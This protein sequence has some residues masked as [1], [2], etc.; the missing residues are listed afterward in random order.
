MND[1]RKALIFIGSRSNYGRL[2]QLI[3]RMSDEYSV[4]LCLACMGVDL[5]LPRY[6]E[7]LVALRVRAD[8]RSDTDCNMA[9]TM[10][11]VALLVQN[12]LVNNY[13][14][15]AVCHGD[16][17]E[18]LGFAVACSFAKIPLVHMEA[19]EYSGNIDNKIRWAVSSLADLQLAPSRLSN[20]N[21]D[22]LA[23]GKNYFVGSPAVEYIKRKMGRFN[24]RIR[25]K[26][27]LVLYHP[28]DSSELD[29]LLKFLDLITEDE[30]ITWVNPNIDPGNKGIVE[31]IKAF[32][33]EHKNIKFEKN[34]PLDD[35]LTRL[36]NCKFIIG[37]TSSGIKEAAV[38]EKWYIMFENRQ[39]NRECDSNVIKVNTFNDVTEA[40]ERI[41]DNSLIPYEYRGLFGD[42]TV[43]ELCMKYINEL[44]GP[45]K[46]I[47][48]SAVNL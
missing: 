24:S 39:Q 37:N 22:K 30:H 32:E 3:M 25:R 26:P 36:A 29:I 13:F 16:R 10:S 48:E 20:E 31:R 38:L 5:K 44:L 27:V 9:T 47:L 33:S 2:Y 15:V 35:Y 45:D 43:T 23:I 14:D 7:N 11:L 12:F 34:L 1:M 42:R 6:M 8:M 17:F 21:L 46:D 19:G 41:I 40:Y 4:S 18:T 28:T